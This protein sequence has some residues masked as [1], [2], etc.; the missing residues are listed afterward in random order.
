MLIR[1]IKNQ[2]P[3]IAQTRFSLPRLQEELQRVQIVILFWPFEKASFEVK[4]TVD[5]EITG[6]CLHIGRKLLQ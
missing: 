6:F 5:S 1:E 3:N 4:H 2:D